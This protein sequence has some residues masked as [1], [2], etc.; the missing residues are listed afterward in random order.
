M[1][2]VAEENARTAGLNCLYR[3]TLSALN[4]KVQ[5]GLSLLR[6]RNSNSPEAVIKHRYPGFPLTNVGLWSA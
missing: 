2:S 6:F 3:A 4:T 1:E 5:D